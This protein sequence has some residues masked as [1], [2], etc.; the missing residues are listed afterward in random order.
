VYLVYILMLSSENADYGHL[1][2]LDIKL[3]A[4]SGCRLEA[5]IA[6]PYR[7]RLVKK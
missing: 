3:A 2:G 7:S 1:Y 5:V 6:D 4:R